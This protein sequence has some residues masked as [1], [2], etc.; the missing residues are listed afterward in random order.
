ML[1]PLSANQYPSY[2]PTAAGN[3]QNSPSQSEQAVTDVNS[4]NPD[5]SDSRSTQHSQQN[6]TL[7]PQHT[8]QQENQEQQQEKQELQEL[9]QRDRE[10]RAHEAAHKAV[11]GSLGG[12]I[13]L[14]YRAGPDGKH[15]AVG[16]E[17]SIDT[18]KVNGNP[19]AT[20]S[21]AQRIQ[22]A[23]LAPADPSNQDRAVAAKASAMAAEARQEMARAGKEEQ[24]QETVHDSAE[25]DKEH[26]KAGASRE[27]RHYHAQQNKSPSLGIHYAI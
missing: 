1:T 23:A 19:Q 22:A 16:G 17:V 24:Q 15:Y 21:K 13:H 2:T 8:P 14:E 18:S 7:S 6:Q 3:T 27:I 26:A 10:V 5:Q 12:S 4:V 9:Q 20:L 25:K 11:A